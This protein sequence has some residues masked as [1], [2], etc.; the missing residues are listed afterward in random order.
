MYIYHIYIS[1]Y[2][3]Y[4][5]IYLYHNVMCHMS[6]V[7]ILTNAQRHIYMLAMDESE[8]SNLNLNRRLNLS[9]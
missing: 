4:H 8:R 1:D 6:H 3:I 9:F 7:S 5:I 2:H